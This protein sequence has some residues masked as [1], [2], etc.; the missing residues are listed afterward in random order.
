MNDEQ[1]QRLVFKGGPLVDHPDW[2]MIEVWKENDE[3]NSRSFVRIEDGTYWDVA[4]TDLFPRTGGTFR[5][6]LGDQITNHEAVAQCHDFYTKLKTKLEKDSSKMK[7]YISSQ[8][9]RFVGMMQFQAQQPRGTF[10]RIL[11]ALKA[12]TLKSGTRAFIE[13]PDQCVVYYNIP[14]ADAVKVLTDSGIAVGLAENE[15]LIPKPE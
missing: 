11:D 4:A 6:T 8:G 12:T 7:A 5:V 14:Q 10:D 2:W 15:L 13:S 1:P 9:I 3:S